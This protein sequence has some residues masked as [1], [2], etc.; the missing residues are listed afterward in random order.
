[1]GKTFNPDL[2][3]EV[4]TAIIQFAYVLNAIKNK[5]RNRRENLLVFHNP[6]LQ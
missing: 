1:M 5:K 4:F 6:R 2:A 3:H